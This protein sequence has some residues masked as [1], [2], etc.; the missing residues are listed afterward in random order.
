MNKVKR[1]EK[2]LKKLAKAEK[3]LIK[4]RSLR[5]WVENNPKINLLN[6]HYY[7][8]KKGFGRKCM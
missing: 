1:L 5:I 6:Y 4:A 8:F 7:K 3:N 2:S